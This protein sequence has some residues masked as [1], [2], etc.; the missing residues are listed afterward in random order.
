MAFV[1]CQK[2]IKNLLRSPSSAEFPYLGS[3]G[4]SSTHLGGGTYAVTGYVDSQN[5]F[6]AMLR[7]QWTCKIK[8]NAD[9]TWSAIDFEVK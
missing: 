5:G 8:E 7:S 9:Q 6:G 2:P 3:A 1:M 4:V